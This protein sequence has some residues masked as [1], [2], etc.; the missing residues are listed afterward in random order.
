MGASIAGPTKSAGPT[1]GAFGVAVHW[2]RVV[3]AAVALVASVLGF[4]SPAAAQSQP[5]TDI[6]QDAFYSEAVGALA[7]GRL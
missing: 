1:S 3:A 7:G 2:R 5:L 4:S 6:P